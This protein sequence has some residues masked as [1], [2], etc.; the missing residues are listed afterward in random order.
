LAI[1]Q[2]LSTEE[3]AAYEA[4]Q[5]AIHNGDYCAAL[6]GIEN[7]LGL[8]VQ[9]GDIEDSLMGKGSVEEFLRLIQSLKETNG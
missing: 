6:Q 3:Q 1:V 8:D 4:F 2:R 7:E 5:C 9:A